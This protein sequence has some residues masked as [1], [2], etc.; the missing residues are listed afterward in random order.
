MKKIDPIAVASDKP[1]LMSEHEQFYIAVKTISYALQGKGFYIESLNIINHFDCYPN[2]SFRDNEGKICQ[3]YVRYTNNFKDLEYSKLDKFLS[4]VY[5]NEYFQQYIAPVFISGTDGQAYRN[6]PLN[7]S[8]FKD[9][10]IKLC[11]IE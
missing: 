8:F 4:T 2:I 6:Q 11:D 7:I 1:T 3:V 10:I 9:V 5:P